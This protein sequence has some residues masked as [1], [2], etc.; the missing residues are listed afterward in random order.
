MNDLTD[1]E[2]KEQVIIRLTVLEQ[3]AKRISEIESQVSEVR[4]DLSNVQ[5]DL[6]KVIGL[7]EG[8]EKFSAKL[9]ANIALWIAG[10]SVF[11][12]LFASK[13]LLWLNK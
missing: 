11:L 10:I 5:R 6:G 3:Q 4:K 1:K 9:K 8:H 13:I 7:I 2:F 12:S